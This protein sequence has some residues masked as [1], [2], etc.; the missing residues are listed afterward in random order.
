MAVHGLESAPAG[1]EDEGERPTSEARLAATERERGNGRWTGGE[2]WVD[3]LG[4]M[5]LGQVSL[6]KKKGLG[7]FR[8]K[9]RETSTDFDF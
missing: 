5:K 4:V 9:K 8:K 6:K 1:A 3:D 2:K 7:R